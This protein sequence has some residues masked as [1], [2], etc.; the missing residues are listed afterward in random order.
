MLPKPQERTAALHRCFNLSVLIHQP[1]KCDAAVVKQFIITA[2]KVLSIQSEDIIRG[3][4]RPWCPAVKKKTMNTTWTMDRTLI[5]NRRTWISE[6]WVC[7]GIVSPTAD[8]RAAWAWGAQEDRCQEL[9]TVQVLSFL[10][11]APKAACVCLLP[12]LCVHVMRTFWCLTLLGCALSI[13]RTQRTPVGTFPCML[14]KADTEGPDCL[15]LGAGPLLLLTTIHTKRRNSTHYQ[16]EKEG[17]KNFDINSLNESFSSLLMM[18]IYV[19]VVVGVCIMI[20]II[21]NN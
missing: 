15:F 5:H 3:L 18:R 21:C 4:T 12:E 10:C 19:W 20:I 8:L 9:K 7:C 14:L 2:L 1:F 11:C 6:C 13:Y 16:E 17:A